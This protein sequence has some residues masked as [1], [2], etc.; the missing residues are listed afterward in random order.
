MVLLSSCFRIAFPKPAMDMIEA[1][2]S[3]HAHNEI[4]SIIYIYMY[5]SVYLSKCTIFY[6]SRGMKV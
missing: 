5:S 4:D 2:Y 3:I 1:M 6:E